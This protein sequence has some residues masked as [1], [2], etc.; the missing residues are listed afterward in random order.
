VALNE[1]FVIPRGLSVANRRDSKFTW[2]RGRHGLNVIDCGDS[3]E[4]R[5]ASVFMFVGNETEVTLRHEV[6]DV[7]TY[8]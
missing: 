8:A 7:L 1:T 5:Y 6:E 2:L 4:H 3:R